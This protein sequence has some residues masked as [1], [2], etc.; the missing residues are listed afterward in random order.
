MG[1]EF[2]AGIREKIGKRFGWNLGST[3]RFQE[4]GNVFSILWVGKNLQTNAQLISLQKENKWIHLNF[5]F[6]LRLNE[7]IFKTWVFLIH[8]KIVGRQYHLKLK[9]TQIK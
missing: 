9:I 4:R 7:L 1:M 6:L 8:N 3:K 5:S 2:G